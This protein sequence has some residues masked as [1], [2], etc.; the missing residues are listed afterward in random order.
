MSLKYHVVRKRD[1]LKEAAPGDMLYYGQIRTNDRITYSELCKQVERQTMSTG[2]DV[3]I[4]I[5]QLVALMEQHLLKGEIVE[6]GPVGNFR[7]T[8]GAPGVEREEDFH[9]SMFRRGKITFV[10]GTLLK[11]ITDRISYEKYPFITKI[12]TQ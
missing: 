9:P 10:A 4:I 11:E 6:L 2:S 3:I 1:M 7:I 12:V 8:A 5:D